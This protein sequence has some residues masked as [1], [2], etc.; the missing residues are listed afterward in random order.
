[1]ENTGPKENLVFYAVILL[2]LEIRKGVLPC[3]NVE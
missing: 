1:M 2:M 3:L